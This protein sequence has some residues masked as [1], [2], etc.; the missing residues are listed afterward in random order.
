MDKE[1]VQTFF[2]SCGKDVYITLLQSVPLATSLN[3]Y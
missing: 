3:N 2:D 1:I